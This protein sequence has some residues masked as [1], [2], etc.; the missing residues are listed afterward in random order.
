MASLRLLLARA[1][2]GGPFEKRLTLFPVHA[3]AWMS[4]RSRADSVPAISRACDLGAT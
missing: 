3:R 2:F 1:S 4:S